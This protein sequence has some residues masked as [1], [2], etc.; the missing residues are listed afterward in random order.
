M[1]WIDLTREGLQAEID[2]PT[3]EHI[4]VHGDNADALCAGL[5]REQRQVERVTQQS[6]TDAVADVGDVGLAG[7]L[8]DPNE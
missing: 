5:L 6:T 7:Y 4:V 8:A 2:D 1:V 3:G